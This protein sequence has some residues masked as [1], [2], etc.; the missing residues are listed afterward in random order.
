M[1]KACRVTKLPKLVSIWHQL[2]A[3]G[4]EWRVV[5]M[6]VLLC[7]YLTYGCIVYS[8]EW[9]ECLA[10]LQSPEWGLPQ[11]LIRRRVCPP[12]HFGYGGRGTL[13]GQGGGLESPN[14]DEG[15][16][17]VVLLIMYF[18][19]TTT[20]EQD[21]SLPSYKVNKTDQYLASADG[22]WRR[23]NGCWDESAIV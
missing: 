23:V 13:A 18:V 6:R 2:K 8:T 7:V 3:A 14:S 22:S 21:K 19:G 4:G 12:P 5:G 11:P 16:Y 1:V 15:T 10:F 20:E 9:A 17:T